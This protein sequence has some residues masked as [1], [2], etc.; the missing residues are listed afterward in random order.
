MSQATAKHFAANES[1]Y[2]F[3]RWTSANLVPSRAMHELYLLPF[4]MAVK[5]AD[6]AS[7]MCAYPHVNFSYNCDSQP[8]LQQTLRERWGFDGYVFSDRRA[9]QSTLASILAGVDVELDET[10]EWYRPELIKTLLDSGEITE[11]NIDDLLRERY[12][13]MFEFGDFDNPPTG[14]GW[15]ALDP[16]PWPPVAHTRSWPSRRRPRAWCCCAIDR[17]LLP[18]NGG[19]AVKTIGRPYWR[20]AGSP[21]RRHSHRAAAIVQEHIRSSSLRGDARAGS[22]QC[23][24]QPRSSDAQVIYNDGEGNVSAAARVAA[25]AD[26]TI[27][28]AG[29]VLARRGTRTAIGAMRTPEAASLAWRKRGARSRPAVGRRHQSAK[30]H[31]AHPGGESQHRCW[32]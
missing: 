15:D 26:V 16:L 23:A 20:G 28:I 12:V 14:F 9:Q 19:G 32:S 3:E 11:A 30:A 25:S 21:A 18:L 7:I 6:V 13:K 4:E 29:D 27:L 24:R 10:P 31:S 2:Q 5:D 8:L 1:E 22:A 17:N